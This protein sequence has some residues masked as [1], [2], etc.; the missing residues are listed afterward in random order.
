M[1]R[2]PHREEMIF[3]GSVVSVRIKSILVGDSAYSIAKSRDSIVTPL[4]AT[5][6]P[7][8]ASFF[9]LL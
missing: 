8:R 2:R 3:L 4:T 7:L 1:N 5:D 6:L 9:G